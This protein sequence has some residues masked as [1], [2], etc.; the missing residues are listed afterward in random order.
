M[1][2]GADATD[3]PSAEMLSLRRSGPK[4]ETREHL[5]RPTEVRLPARALGNTSELVEQ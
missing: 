5:P 3:Q 2:L 1:E 4:V